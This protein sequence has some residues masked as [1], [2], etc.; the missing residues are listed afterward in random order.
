MKFR[1]LHMADCHLG[2]RQYNLRER[3][4]DFARA[5]YAVIDT[6]IQERVDFVVLAGDLFQKRTIDALTLGQAMRGLERLAAA[7]IPCVAVEGNHEHAYYG[8]R[9]SWMDFLAQ[10]GLLQLLDTR[11]EDGKAI[12]EEYVKREGSYV[13]P[14]PGVRVHGMRYYGASTPQAFALYATALEEAKLPAAEYNIIVAHAGMEGVLPDQG[15]LSHREVRVLHPH[16]DYLAL[17]H[18]HKPY[19]FDNWIYNPGSLENCSLA[20]AEWPERGY[21]LVD[22]DTSRKGVK[23][24]A[25]LKANA[26]RPMHR[27]ALKTDLLTSFEA[28]ESNCRELL[29]RKARDLGARHATDETRPIVELQL[30]GV[31]PFDRAGLD[32]GKLEELAREAFAPL[33]VLI[34]NLTRATA[35]DLDTGEEDVPRRVLERQILAQ[36]FAQDAEFSAHGEGWAAT[37]LAL[38]TLALDGASAEAIVNDLAERMARLQ[39]APPERTAAENGVGQAAVESDGTVKSDGTVISD[40]AEATEADVSAGESAGEDRAP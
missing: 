23:H 22:V 14:L 33:H 2:Y 5:F 40:G 25:V 27:L 19:E 21:Y 31:L 9:F 4:N 38:K 11:I 34:R 10:R 29:A 39:A 28:L 20:E 16:A 3:I 37:A 13:E 12:V 36:L 26:R 32:I 30:T 18:I 24:D 15:G 6:A 1:F 35:F 8:E 7:D 17:G